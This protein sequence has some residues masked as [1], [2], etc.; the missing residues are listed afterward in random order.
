MNKQALSLKFD[1][2]DIVSIDTKTLGALYLDFLKNALFTWFINQ[3]SAES[4]WE[5]L[6]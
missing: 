6:T 3:K 2:N 5:R 1:T 4:L